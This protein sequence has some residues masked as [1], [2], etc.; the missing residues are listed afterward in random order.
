MSEMAYNSGVANFR[1]VGL[2]FGVGELEFPLELAVEQQ[3]WS[4]YGISNMGKAAMRIVEESS[5]TGR[6]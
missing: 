3:P 4:P 1:V 6:L 5:W 2:P